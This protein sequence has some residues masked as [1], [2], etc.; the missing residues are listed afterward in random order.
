MGMVTLVILVSCL[1]PRSHLL[2]LTVPT[3]SSPSPNISP[4]VV[5]ACFS[6]VF[7]NF[8]SMTLGGA[9]D[10]FLFVLGQKDKMG[11]DIV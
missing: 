10:E 1:S 2:T 11:M 7:F 8:S 9:I 6:D 3:L 5:L 4:S